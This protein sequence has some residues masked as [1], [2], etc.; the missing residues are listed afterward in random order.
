LAVVQ[1]VVRIE[2]DPL[3]PVPEICAA[4]MA[5]TPYHQ[6]QEES[7]LIGIQEAIEQRLAFL[8]KGAEQVAEPV[9][10]PSREQ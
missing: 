3:K 5:V 1:P 7:I 9:R 2:L 8:K 6:G 4:I 10:E